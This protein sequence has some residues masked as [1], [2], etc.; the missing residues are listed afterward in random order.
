VSKCLEVSLVI[1]WKKRYEQSMPRR[2]NSREREPNLLPPGDLTGYG[3]EIRH[4]SREYQ[5][6]FGLSPDAVLVGVE[7]L[8]KKYNLIPIGHFD[9]GIFST[10]PDRAPDVRTLL[11]SN[12]LQELPEIAAALQAWLTT[13]SSAS[14]Q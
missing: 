7:L 5:E 11:N 10:P 4:T 6:H 3:I 9:Q 1:D 12:L 14:D 2:Y 8:P 13:T